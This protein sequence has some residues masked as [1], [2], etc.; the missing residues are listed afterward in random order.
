MKIAQAAL[1]VI[2]LAAGR[3]AAANEVVE[4]NTTAVDVL[5][6]GGQ[7]NLTLTRGLT[8]VAVAIH[9]ALNAIN[10]R[11]EP[12]VFDGA[13]EPNAAPETAVATAARDA[14]VLAVPAFGTVSQQ[15]AA[16]AMVDA[17]YGAAPARIPDGPGKTAGVAVGRAAAAAIVSL[18]KD[19]GAT[20]DASYTPGGAPGQW[21]PHPNPRAPTWPSWRGPPAR[22]RCAAF[23]RRSTGP[24]FTTRRASRRASAWRI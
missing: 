22:T 9:D 1:L 24:S 23:P 11:Y 15:A 19:D 18:R 10:W 17:A 7:S 6:A 2:A 4:W 5:L 3:A 13:G 21:R 8:M 14:L 12:Y 20:R 16:I